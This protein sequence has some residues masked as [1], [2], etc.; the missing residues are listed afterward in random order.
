MIINIDFEIFLSMLKISLV[1]F[2]F[3]EVVGLLVMMSVFLL[4]N[5]LVIVIC[6]FCFLDRLFIFLYLYL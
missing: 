3:S 6:C 4:I 5:V 1:F 2:L